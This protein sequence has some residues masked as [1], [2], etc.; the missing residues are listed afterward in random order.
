MIFQLSS[1]TSIQKHFHSSVILKLKI[2]CEHFP[3]K[4]FSVN[5]KMTNRANHIV[6]PRVLL[7]IRFV[8]LFIIVGAYVLSRLPLK[9]F[10]N[11]ISRRKI[12]YFNVKM[13]I[14]FFENVSGSAG[15]VKKLLKFLNKKSKIET[16]FVHFCFHFYEEFVRGDAPPKKRTT[17][18]Q[19]DDRI[20]Q[21]VTTQ[22]NR[23]LLEYLKGIASCYRMDGWVSGFCFVWQCIFASVFVRLNFWGMS[24]CSLF[25]ILC[26]S[27]IKIAF[28]GFKRGKTKKNK[29]LFDDQP[30]WRSWKGLTMFL[31]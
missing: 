18:Q 15:D 11:T 5:P 16:K 27:K 12:V 1:Y 4:K 6:S 28:Q 22:H 9:L 31:K 24:A 19:L 30:C 21:I 14:K 2:T 23:T 7:N 13:P 17:Y 29:N 8:T 26:Q 25:I 10:K 3:R 20:L